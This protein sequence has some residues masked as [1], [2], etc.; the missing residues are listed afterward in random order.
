[1]QF[2][3]DALVWVVQMATMIATLTFAYLFVKHVIDPA[4]TNWRN[5]GTK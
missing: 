4:V 1:M 2:V 5:G 3:A